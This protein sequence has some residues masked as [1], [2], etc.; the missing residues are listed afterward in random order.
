MSNNINV[1]GVI[2]DII[3]IIV[4]LLGGME[5]PSEKKKEI[6]VAIAFLEELS[7]NLRTSLK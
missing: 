7:E 6:D 1:A 2:A 3:K 4:H 5:V